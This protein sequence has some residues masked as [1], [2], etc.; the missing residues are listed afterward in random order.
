[1]KSTVLGGDRRRQDETW[2]LLLDLALVAGLVL[3]LV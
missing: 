3:M 2:D 1:M